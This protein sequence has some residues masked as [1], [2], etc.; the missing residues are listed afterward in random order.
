L[1]ENHDN[2]K[3]KT[4]FATHYHELIDESKKLKWVA[5][6]SV[7][8]W[9]NDENLVFLRKIIPGWMK[10]SYWIQV[11]KL[12]GVS[13]NVIL[14]AKNMLYNLESNSKSHN[15]LSLINLLWEENREKITIKQAE[16]KS[17]IDKKIEELDINSLTPINALNF[18]N[19]LKSI[20]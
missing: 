4:L 1:K 3:A 13:D 20:K 12:A 7:A 11:A 2:I 8:V 6:F 16:S 19:N 9:E 10:K 14:E 17:I 18:L 15:Q 5:N